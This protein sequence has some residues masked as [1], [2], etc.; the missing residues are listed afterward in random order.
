MLD[1][2]NC[3]EV[4]HTVSGLCSNW[5]SPSTFRRIAVDI[6]AGKKSITSTIAAAASVSGADVL[7]FQNIWKLGFA[8]VFKKLGNA[9]TRFEHIFGELEVNGGSK[10]NVREMTKSHIELSIGTRLFQQTQWNSC[11]KHFKQVE[12]I[13]QRLQGSPAEGADEE[14]D[15]HLSIYTTVA[16]IYKHWNN[17]AFYRAFR[18]TCTAISVLNKQTSSTNKCNQRGSWKCKDK[19]QRKLKGSAALHTATNLSMTCWLLGRPQRGSWVVGR[20]CGSKRSPRRTA[21]SAVLSKR[22]SLRQAKR[23]AAFH[24]FAHQQC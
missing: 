1:P 24:L 12:M 6:S 19:L 18:Y 8:D 9:S 23:D 4:F 10:S 17:L 5:L 2:N 13:Q 14:T 11:S 7:Y 20:I 16:S 3:D 22:G 15:N 21:G